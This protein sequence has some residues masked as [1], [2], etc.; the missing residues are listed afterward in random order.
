MKKKFFRS[1]NVIFR[2]PEASA[3]GTTITVTGTVIWTKA[4]SSV[5]VGYR[6]VGASNWTHKASSSK[7][8]N[9]SIANATAGATYEVC[10]Y[11]KRANVYDYSSAVEVT[12]PDAQAEPEA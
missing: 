7:E 6:V 12:V 3:E 8:V 5:G 11:L 9:T 1:N 4:Y 10:L 2:G